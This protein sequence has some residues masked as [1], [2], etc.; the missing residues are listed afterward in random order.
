MSGLRPAPHCPKTPYLLRILSLLLALS[1]EMALAGIPLPQINTNNIIVVTNAPYGAIGDGVTTNTTAIQNAINT[2]ALGGTTNGL[3]GGTVEFPP[4]DYLCG[5]LTMKSFVN[6]QIG[7]GATLQMLPYGSY[8]GGTS[9]TDF[10]SASKLHDLEISGSGTIDGQGAVWWATNNATPGGISRPKAMFAPSTCTNILVRDVT[11][12]N[13]PNTHISF[14][15]VCVNVTV[16]HININT[17]YGTPNTDGIDCSGANVLISN[18]HITDGDDFIA[19]GDG[20]TN[21][22]NHDLTITN[23]LFGT[24]HGVSIGSFTQGGLSN[25]LVID[26]VWTNGTSGIHL[27]SDDDRGGLVQNLRYI[28]L[29]MTNTQIPIFLYSYYTN[30]GTSTGV[31]VDKAAAYP[32]FP[33]TNTTPIWRDITFSNITA[34]PT[35]GFAAGIIW[36]KPELSFSNVVMDHVNITASKYFQLYN[37]QGVQLI[38]SQITAPS[39]N[40]FALYNAEMIV[41]NRTP[42]TNL[43][44]LEGISTNGYVNTLRL[45]NATATLRATNML[46]G[47][48]NITLSGSTLTISNN[49]TLSLSNSINYFLGTNAATV[50]VKGNLALGGSNNI[51][52]GNG[53]TNGTYTLMTYTGALSGDLP[54]LGSTPSGYICALNTNTAGQIKLIVTSPLPGV[55]AGLSALGTNL[56]IRLNW[57]PSSNAESYNLKRSTTNGGPYFLLGN[58]ATTNYSDAMVNPGKTYYYV[59]SATNTAGESGN[60]TQA[61][62]IPLPSNTPTNIVMQ[63]SGGQM[64]LFWPPDHLGWRL[65]SQTNSQT[66]GLG[67]NWVSVSNSTAT[68]LTSISLDPANASVFYRLV[69]P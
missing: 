8:P 23:C 21:S 2:A 10:I 52:A 5:P 55:P 38:D 35:N 62:A 61:S 65:E 25:L 28:N 64:I 33:V 45:Y 51:N 42:S 44:K 9:P 1:G 29:A 68:N 32:A 36:G 66:V 15:F 47:S 53:F 17:P 4:G 30:A 63:V 6:L 40:T 24:G 3:S 20:H 27:K 31:T 48:P 18:S 46:D 22:F 14:R 67:T 57:L 43:V 16:D 13:P 26:C 69:L 37:A 19:M 60:S 54:V 39:T 7:A 59:V 11:L 41:T 34:L 49:L 12:Q 58:L 50:A 56:L